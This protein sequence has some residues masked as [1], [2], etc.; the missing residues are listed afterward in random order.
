MRFVCTSKQQRNRLL[1]IETIIDFNVSVTLP[2]SVLKERKL[3]LPPKARRWSKGVITRVPADVPVEEVKSET[4]AVMA[5]RITRMDEGK[6]VPTSAVIIAFEDELPKEVFIHFHR[7]KVNNYIP[8]PIRCNKCQAFGHRISSCEASVV[9]CSRCSSKSHDY[10]NCPVDRSQAKCANCGQNHNAA[11]K[12]CSSY[13]TVNKTLI[14]SAKQGISY[15]DAALQVKKSTADKCSTSATN[16][17]ERPKTSVS[18]TAYTTASAQTEEPGSAAKQHTKP[19]LVWVGETPTS[20][21]AATMHSE[22][23]AQGPFTQEMPMPQTLLSGDQLR[24]DQTL[25]LMTTLATAMLWLINSMPPADGQHQVISQLT[26]VVTVLRELKSKMQKT[27][28]R[29]SEE[30]HPKFTSISA[31]N[32]VDVSNETPVITNYVTTGT[33]IDTG[34]P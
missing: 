1:E 7:Y 33:E 22:I 23:T 28:S 3:Q 17:H 12:G 6:V 10:T 2:Y 24:Q 32:G 9:T 19:T 30:S 20:A 29:N 15:T 18:T 27:P 21:A 13:K 4:S 34:E 5:R 11:Y 8:K 25:C 16:Q 14:V 26:T 31:A